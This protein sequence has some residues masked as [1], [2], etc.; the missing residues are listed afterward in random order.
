[1]EF[2]M[3]P[4]TFAL[5]VAILFFF[6]S[7][8]VNLLQRRYAKS[9]IDRLLNQGESALNSLTGLHTALGKLE[10]TC[11]LELDGT[12][13]PKELGRSIR[14]TRNQIQSTMAD[15]QKNLRSFRQYRQKEKT[16]ERHQKRLEKLRK[17][18]LGK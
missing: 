6:I 9:R 1:M 11:T 12:S 2:P 17:K 7:L 5:L 13:S 8:L 15:I 10:S 18:R 4:K 14:I 3:D 16:R